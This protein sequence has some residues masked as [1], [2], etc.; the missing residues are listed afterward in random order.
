MQISEDKLKIVNDINYKN[1]TSNQKKLYY[2]F[3]NF[4]KKHTVYESI[5]EN[6]KVN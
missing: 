1:S 3:S 6:M 4:L 5:P 2:E